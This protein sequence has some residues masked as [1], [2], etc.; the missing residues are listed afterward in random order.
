M[1]RLADVVWSDGPVAICGA[2]AYRKGGGY[3]DD[4]PVPPLQKSGDLSGQV[5]PEWDPSGLA[6]FC[7]ADQ[8][9]TAIEIHVVAMQAGDFADAQAQPVK[10]YEDHAIYLPAVLRV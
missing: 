7:L 8:K 4:A 3:V 1:K 10:Q 2:G 6:E 9:K 5:R